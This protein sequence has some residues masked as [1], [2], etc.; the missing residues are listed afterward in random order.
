MNLQAF[1]KENAITPENIK[2]VASNRFL[3][4]IET[5]TLDENGKTVKEVRKQPIEWEIK[6]ISAQHDEEIRKGCM[7]KV[8]VPG[9]R[10]QYT[11]EFDSDKYLGKLA[12]ECTVFPNLKS[13]ELQNSYGVMGEDN[14]LKVMLMPGEYAEYLAAVQD[15][16]GF[17]ETMDDKV[18]EVKNY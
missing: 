11:M 3:E 16:C 17:S 2:V 9:K 7:K 1:L 8:S 6:P 14:L 15:L 18:E 13:K 5:E 4:E 10:G 12:T